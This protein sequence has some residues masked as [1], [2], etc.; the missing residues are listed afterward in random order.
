MVATVIEHEHDHDIK[1]WKRW[2]FFYQ[3][4][5][6]WVNVFNFCNNSRDNRRHYVS[7]YENGISCTR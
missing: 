6:Y 1:G 5:R 4:Q 3:S 7:Y 2:V